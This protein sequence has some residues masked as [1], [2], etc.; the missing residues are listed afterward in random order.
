M[1]KALHYNEEKNALLSTI[2]WHFHE[3]INVNY[4]LAYLEFFANCILCNSSR[5]IGQLSLSFRGGHA[6]P[7]GV[8][9]PVDQ[10]LLHPRLLLVKGDKSVVNLLVDGSCPVE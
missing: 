3:D 7:D 2:D 5:N 10:E 8:V 6:L 9:G 4:F 1:L